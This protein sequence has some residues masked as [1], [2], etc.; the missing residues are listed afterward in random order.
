MAYTMVHALI[1]EEVQRRF[2]RKVDYAIYILGA[3]APDAVH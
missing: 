3:I 2:E 1:A